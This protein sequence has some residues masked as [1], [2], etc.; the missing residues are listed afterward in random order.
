MKKNIFV[1]ALDDFTRRLFGT[2]YRAERYHFHSLLPTKKIVAASSYS[3]PDLLAEA[4]Q[5]LHD[6]D[7]PIDGIVC[8]WDFPAT[9]MLPTLRQ[10]AGLPTTPT[11][12]ILHCEHLTGVLFTF[13]SRYYFTIGHQVVFRLGRWSSRLPTRFHVSR[14]TLDPDLPSYLSYTGLLPSL[15]GFP[16]PFY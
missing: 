9:I 12:S 11:E 8:Y 1:I 4:Q 16:T 13:P 5:K 10:F 3:M 2:V 7:G 14:G 15:V 6:F